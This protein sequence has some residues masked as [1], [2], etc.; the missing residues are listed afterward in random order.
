MTFVVK[1]IL[2]KAAGVIDAAADEVIFA[3]VMK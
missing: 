2:V 1:L 3:Y